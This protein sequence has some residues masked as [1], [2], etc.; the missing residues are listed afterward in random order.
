M[1][2]ALV[3]FWLSVFLLVYSYAGYP[4]LMRALSLR[5]P[6]PER[7]PVVPPAVSILLVAHNEGPRIGRRLRNLMALC[8]PKAR[9]EILVGSDGSTDDTVERARRQGGGVT[10]VAYQRR[11]GKSAVLND[12]VRRARGQILVLADA[13]QTFAADALLQLVRNFADPRVGAVSG[14]LILTTHQRSEA[15]GEGMGF[16]WRYEKMI[17]S[18]ESRFDSTVGATGAI[19]AIRRELYEP[20]P[21]GTLLDDVVVPLAIAKRGYRVLFDGTARAYDR[22]SRSAREELTRKVRTIAGNFQLFFRDPLL[23]SPWHNRLWFQI[24]SHKALRLLSPG[25][26][27]AAFAANLALVPIPAYRWIL[28]AQIAFYALAIAGFRQRRSPRRSLLLS[29]PYTICLLNGAVVLAFFRFAAGTQSAAWDPAIARSA[30]PRTGAPR[31]IGL[32]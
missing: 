30:A 2:I 28:A 25:L 11:R 20:L 26:M 1:D 16:Y 21:E 3:V 17:R 19:Y 23:L 9:V 7:P 31:V 10:V 8:Y 32:R 4:L 27:A 5:R 6:Q 12:L 22:A 15:V 24:V 18:A 13:R 29:V 14:S